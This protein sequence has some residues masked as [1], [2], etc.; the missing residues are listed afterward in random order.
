MFSRVLFDRFFRIQTD[1]L[2]LLLA[3][4]VIL[5]GYGSTALAQ[6]ASGGVSGYVADQLGGALSATVHLVQNDAV[7]R[8]AETNARGLF[9]FPSVPVG[10]YRI[11]TERAGFQPRSSA[12]FYVGAS[13]ITEV[14]LTLVV[15]PLAQH[16]VVTAAAT[17]LT[18]SQSGAPV[19][20]NP[21]CWK[22]YASFRLLLL[23]RLVG[24]GDVRRSLFGVVQ[25]TSTRC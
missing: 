6:E 25:V 20:V 18:D 3:S 17:D 12:L 14:D 21:M 1:S 24:E 13:V 5:G 10:R 22:R 7:I 9:R 11:T 4:V 16:V 23:C 15:G 8:D 19:S 2:A